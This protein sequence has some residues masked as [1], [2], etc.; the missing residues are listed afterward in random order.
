[1]H[2][3]KAEQARLVAETEIVHAAHNEA[4]R[5]VDEARDE[6]ERLRS[7]C[8]AYVDSRLAEF[9][10]LLGRALRTVGKGR[11]HLR[12]PVGAPFDYEEWKPP[13]SGSNGRDAG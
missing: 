5:I 6:A 2:E 4:K 7:D 12:S 11:Q 10:E 3:G 13:A 8:D 9:E 1:V